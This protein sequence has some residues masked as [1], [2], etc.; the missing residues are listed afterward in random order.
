M[1][2]SELGTILATASIAQ[3]GGWP[4]YRC[5]AD[6]SGS[7]DISGT[8]ARWARRPSRHIRENSAAMRCTMDDTG[9]HRKQGARCALAPL[10]AEAGLPGNPFKTRCDARY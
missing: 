4:A 8:G 7:D 3:C 10:P 9:L 6:N 5:G 1:P 2:V